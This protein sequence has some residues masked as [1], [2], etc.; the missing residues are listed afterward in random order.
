MSKLRCRSCEITGNTE[1]HEEINLLVSTSRHVGIQTNIKIGVVLP[2]TGPYA[3]LGWD[4][5]KGVEIAHKMK[6]FLFGKKI[7]LYWMD[8]GSDEKEAARAVE[9]LIVKERVCG[10]IGGATNS[11]SMATAEACDRFQVPVIIPAASDPLITSEYKS[12][13]NICPTASFEA[14]L[15][16]IHAFTQLNA[17]RASII[18]DTKR[19]P[20]EEMAKSFSEAFLALGG[21]IEPPLSIISDMNILSQLMS[22]KAKRPEVVYAPIFQEEGVIV[23]ELAKKL[24]IID[25]PIIFSS[26]AKPSPDMG[27]LEKA[28]YFSRF[29]PMS[30]KTKFAKNYLSYFEETTG[31]KVGELSALG[32]DAYLV[33]LDA[34]NR[35]NS[36]EPSMIIE[37]LGY[38]R[39]FGGITG[40]IN[41]VEDRNTIKDVP[42]IKLEEGKFETITIMPESKIMPI[43]MIEQP[44]YPIPKQPEKTRLPT[45]TIPY[46]KRK[47]SYQGVKKPD[48][49]IIQ[50]RQ[51]LR[52]AFPREQNDA[53]RQEAN[54]KPPQNTLP[55][56]SLKPT[57]EQNLDNESRP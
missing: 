30:A 47:E 5:H 27:V 14:E 52:K 23:S 57:V 51:E 20:S 17:K 10:I 36:T 12:A 18:I 15:A 35:A 39:A 6:P 33:L 19:D 24:G 49:E 54:E 31:K 53:P 38:T 21:E 2:C 41:I 44:P 13:F 28:I 25:I 34:I 48:Q 37:A 4:I 8:H 43:R 40:R 32:A 11:F 29:H 9:D 22:I 1:D 16:A 45:E 55:L 26:F 46:Q 56:K 7:E 3:A 42:V 50:Q